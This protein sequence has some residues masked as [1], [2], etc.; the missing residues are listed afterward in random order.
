MNLLVIGG[1]SFV[2]RSLVELAAAERHDVT[3]F[4]RGEQEPDGLPAVTHVHGDRDGD[5]ARL[6]DASFDAVIDSSG[7]V[8]RVVEASAAALAQ[9]T[10]RYL[11]VSTTSVYADDVPPPVDEGSPVH[12]PPFPDTEDVTGE[13]YGPLKVACE[14]VVRRVYGD[15]ATIV[16]PGY[17]VGPYDPTERLMSWLRRASSGGEMI[18]PGPPDEPI[19]M[20]DVR[21][22]AAFMLRLLVDDRPGTF[23]VVGPGEPLTMRRFLETAVD[24]AG[25]GTSLVWVDRDT[26]FSVGDEDERYRL[27]P[28]WHPEWPGV[29]RYDASR[30]IEAGLEHRSFRATIHD[31]L[32]WD[33]GRPQEPLPFGPSPDEERTLLARWRD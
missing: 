18:A 7:Y 12:T 8:P 28:M 32:A 11:F 4:H 17:I 26:A 10:H 3:V 2:G 9:R 6:G 33:R 16:R 23:G 1:T 5:L 30:A 13:S 25:A 15:R 20:V 14:D 24:E 27:F 19:Q 21:D 29:H 31:T 22:L